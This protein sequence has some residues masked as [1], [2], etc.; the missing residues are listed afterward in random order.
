MMIAEKNSAV[1][2]ALAKLEVLSQEERARM[3]HEFREMMRM[4]IEVREEFAEKQG[5]A[6]AK[7]VLKLSAENKSPQ[8]IADYCQVPLEKVLEI[9]E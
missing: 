1:K 2:E 6:L 3:L 8:E 4:D 9:L 7:K 5:I